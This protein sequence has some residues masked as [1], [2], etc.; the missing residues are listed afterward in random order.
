MEKLYP[1][2]LLD[3]LVFWLYLLLSQEIFKTKLLCINDKVMAQQIIRLFLDNEHDN[4]QFLLYI[5]HET[6]LGGGGGGCWLR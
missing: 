3:T 6:F 4:Y 5:G 1:M 2:S